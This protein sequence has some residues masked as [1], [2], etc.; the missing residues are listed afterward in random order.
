MEQKLLHILFSDGSD[1]VNGI[2]TVTVNP[3]NDPVIAS[4][5]SA[6]TLKNTSTKN[7]FSC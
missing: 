4:N 6:S 1:S 7:T 2:L 5:V 3:V